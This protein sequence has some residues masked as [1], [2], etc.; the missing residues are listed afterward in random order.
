MLFRSPMLDCEPKGEEVLRVEGLCTK[1]KLGVLK[2]ISF[3]VRSGEMLAIGGLVGSGKELLGR[4]LFGLEKITGGRIVLF[5]RELQVT[6][7]NPGNMISQGVVYFPADRT[8]EGLFLC[9][10][11]LENVSLCNLQLF[12]RF[13]LLRRS[14]ERAVG[15]DVADKLNIRP[16][17][18][19]KDVEYFS[20]GNQQKVVLA[21]GLI[22]ETRLFIFDEVSKGVD[23]GSKIQ[24]YNFIH[25]LVRRGMAVILISSDLPEVLHLPHRILVMAFSRIIQELKRDEATQEKLLSHYFALE[26]SK[27]MS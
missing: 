3:T 14:K 25:D 26:N 21:R 7:I 8:C 1:G 4:T 6:H 15:T 16:L 17:D 22:C 9:R 23:V 24:I 5:G 19:K 11:L 2:D 20:G 27:T 13:G 12:E 10:P 18:L